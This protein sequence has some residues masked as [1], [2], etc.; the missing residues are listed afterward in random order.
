MDMA[1]V[2]VCTTDDFAKCVGAPVYRIDLE[3]EECKITYPNLLFDRN[4]IGGR[5]MMCSV[6]TPSI[7]SN[8]GRGDV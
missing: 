7:G 5:G 6:L 2:D 4:I 3:N 1:N 8:K